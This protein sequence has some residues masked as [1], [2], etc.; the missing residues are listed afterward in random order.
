MS[1]LPHKT[2]TEEAYLEFERAS[3]TKH[4][5]Y[6]GEIFAMAGAS[7]NHNRITGNSF[8]SLYAQLRGRSCEIFQNDLRL[9][10]SAAGLYTYPDIIV[11]CG[12]PA[13]SDDKEDTLTNPTLIIEVLSA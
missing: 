12:K 9:K 1:A 3:D 5:F 10:V 13:L 4:E 6:R 2:W 8:G 11:V 7:L